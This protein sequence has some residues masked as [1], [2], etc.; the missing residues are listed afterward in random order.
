MP[1]PYRLTRLLILVLT[2]LGL[3]LSACGDQSTPS[4]SGIGQGQATQAGQTTTAAAAAG[5]TTAASSGQGAM[6]D[7]GTP[8]NQTLIVQTFDGK[9]STPDQMNPLNNY[10]IWRGFRELGWSY[11]WE[12]DTATGKSYPEL[13]DGMP[14]V[15][16]DKHTQFEVKIR[17]GVYWSDGVEFTTDDI[18]YTLDTMFKYKS[19]LTNGNVAA[20]TN[21]IKS[22]KAIDKYTF[23][24]ETTNPAYDFVTVMGVYTWA[25]AFIPV[26][27]HVFEKQAD[28]T[29]FKNNNPVTLG[30]YTV[31]AYDP[32][33]FWQLWQLRDDWQRSGW[34]NLGT[35]KPKYVYYK[36]FGTEETRTLAFSQNQYDMDTFMSP[37]SIA[38]AQAKNPAIQTFSPTLPYNDMND[39]CSYGVYMN[40]QK[41]PFD[42]AEVR[43]AL[44]LTMNL[45]QVGITAVN[46]QF[47]ASALPIADTPITNPIY[48][49]PLTQWLTDFKL[50]DGY[51]P[52]NANFGNDMVSKLKEMGMSD[53]ALPKGDDVTKSFGAGW[54][55]NDPAEAEKLMNSVG[56]KKGSDGFYMTADGKPWS[57]EFVIPGDWNKVMQRIGFSIADSWKKAGFNINARQVDNGEFGTVQTTNSKFTMM[58]NWS[59]SCVYNSNFL[60]T[61]RSFTAQNVKDVTSSDALVGNYIRTTDPTIFKLIADSQ[62]LDNTSQAF[63]DN[64]K[65][66]MK[67]LVTGM[68]EINFMNIPT[69]IPTNSY[70]WKNYTKQNNFYAAP[71]SWW[72][73]FKKQIVTI[74][75]TGK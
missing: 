69:T 28:V 15:L 63:I 41:A 35:P 59:N 72:S 62:Q 26:P 43:W 5:Q 3:L 22:Y 9:T 57:L 71:Y 37:D 17:P 56:M 67:E 36:D 47:K 32:N 10:A 75:P 7:Q 48:V 46:G 61:W 53:S 50:S 45:Q 52:F 38:A 55:K 23:Q 19:K 1:K 29:T 44:A 25:S 2:V 74:E 11:L 12:D 58:L 16:D 27:K 21:Y 20:L 51:Q 8:R 68:Q 73:S 60:N 18:I 33:G 14:K 34:G 65:S 30:P 4:T 66:I 40:Q 39:A 24:V 31:K 64:G 6:T 70:Y 42:K 49:Q 54:W 13:A